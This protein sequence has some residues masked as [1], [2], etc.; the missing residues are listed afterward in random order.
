MRRSLRR[1]PALLAISAVT[2]GVL[3]I[4]AS[5]GAR[6]L[7]VNEYT[8]PAVDRVDPSTGH[9]HQIAS[10]APLTSA[11]YLTFMSNGNIAVT[12]ENL[13]GIFTVKPNN[14]HI[15]LLTDK[16]LLGPYDLD[17]DPKGNLIVANY[18]STNGQ[19]IVRVNPKTGHVKV[20]SRGPWLGD[21]YSV[22]VDP[23]DGTIYVLDSGGAVDRLKSDGTLKTIASGPPFSTDLWGFARSPDGTLFVTDD[24]SH[25]LLRVNPKTGGVHTVAATGI[26]ND[27]FG[28]VAPSNKVVYTTDY[29]TGSVF[30]VKVAT[31]HV[32]PVVTGLPPLIGIEVAP[33]G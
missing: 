1:P 30:R 21:P 33:R 6:D 22:Q 17:T 29:G 23:H 8:T 19:K 25:S 24:A 31:G 11:S 7:Y 28:V 5:A 12:D 10:G 26:G 9:V 32:S 16:K 14:G 27:P 13:P 2:A 20:L 18:G 15:H 4:T 3:A